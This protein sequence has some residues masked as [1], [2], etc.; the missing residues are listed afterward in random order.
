VLAHR[1]GGVDPELALLAGLVHDIGALAVLERVEGR[2][3]LAADA[4]AVER[5]IRRLHAVVG[6]LVLETW[7]FP[8]SA[9]EAAARHERLW[10]AR[11]GP[12]GMVH[13][14]VDV[15]TVANL[16]AHLGSAHPLGSV[17]WDRVPAFSRLGLAPEDS[18]AAVREARE[19]LA[20]LERALAGG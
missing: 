16:H 20:D 7:G 5:L 2:P 9:V 8:A 4:G 6:P 14:V 10:E 13:R 15:V 19:E 12:D 11:E 1:V 18:V 17:P 3:A